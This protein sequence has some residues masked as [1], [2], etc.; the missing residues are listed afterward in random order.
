MLSYDERALL[1]GLA[2]D[3][4]NA[5]GFIV[6]AGTFVGGSTLALSTGLTARGEAAHRTIHSYDRLELDEYAKG[7]Y[8]SEFAELRVGSSL[9]PVFEENLAAYR[10][11][12][13]LH[14]GEVRGYTWDAA[15][16]EILFIDIAKSWEVNAHVVS[17]FFP[18]LI[19]GQSVVIQ[20]DLVHWQY[21][22]CAIVMEFL[23]DHFAYDG[24]F[25]YASSVWRCV[26]P[27]GR[28][29]VE[30]DWREQIGLEEGLRLLRRAARR[31]GGWG[32]VL[33]ELARAK[34]LL[35]FDKEVEA[36]AEV[37]RV[38]DTYGSEVPFIDEAYTTLRSYAQA[39]VGAKRL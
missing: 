3:H 38:Q 4:F 5:Q 39:A 13:V 26:K 31:A 32:A 14:E 19:P 20:Q 11:L 21:P 8:P 37:E 27:I 18:S 33:L 25:W 36:I 1:F 7:A 6:D 29:E 17:Q 23:A 30:I 15:P 12:I 28:D 10:H 22:W 34:L 35:D 2:R 16:I 24:W 9:R